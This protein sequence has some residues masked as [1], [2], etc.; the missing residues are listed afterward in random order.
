MSRKAIPLALVFVS[1]LAAAAATTPGTAAVEARPVSGAPHAAAARAPARH[2]F[3]VAPTGNEARYRVRE[4][5]AGVSLPNDAVGVTQEVTGSLAVET[6]G[7]QLRLVPGASKFVV[8]LA[9]LKS[10][11]DRRDGY[12]KR[13][14]LVTDS[15]PTAVLVPTA[16]TGLTPQALTPGSRT[17]TMTGDLT[18]RTVTHPTTWTVTARFDRGE[19]TGKAATAFT[20]T[21]LQLVQPRVPIVLSVEDTIKLEYDFRLVPDTAKQQGQ[22]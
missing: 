18:I 7:K 16:F 3:V 8:N 10:D 20:F 17:F 11:R 12:I 21:D 9:G 15:F 13:R 22:R 1:M 2:R 6:E 5:L 14:T 19:V 4:Q